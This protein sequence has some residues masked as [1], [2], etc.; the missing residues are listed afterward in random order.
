MS[1]KDFSND[2]GSCLVSSLHLR[3]ETLCNEAFGKNLKGK[4]G[5]NVVRSR[6]G[7]PDTTKRSFTELVVSVEYYGM[8]GGCGSEQLRQLW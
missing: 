8:A 4:G 1:S 7:T 6:K 5:M 3:M 2:K